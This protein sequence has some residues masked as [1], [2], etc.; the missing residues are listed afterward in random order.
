ML[1]NLIYM[2]IS[3]TNECIVYVYL[4]LF[5]WEEGKGYTRT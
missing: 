2:G 1:Q 5:H 3:C 4:T